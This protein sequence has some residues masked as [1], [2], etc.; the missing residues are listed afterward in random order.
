[1]NSAAEAF[2][3]LTLAAFGASGLADAPIT[4]HSVYVRAEPSLLVAQSFIST[5]SDVLATI[6]ME[7]NHVC[8]VAIPDA[9]HSDPGRKAWPAF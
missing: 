8:D 5:A 2:C 7:L 6:R 3:I 1:M 9:S 4:R